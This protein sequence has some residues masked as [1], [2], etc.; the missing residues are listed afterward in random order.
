MATAVVTHAD[1]TPTPPPMPGYTWEC[2]TDDFGHTTCSAVA[3][4]TCGLSPDGKWVVPVPPGSQ[5]LI[6]APC[7][8]GPPN[9]PRAPYPTTI[10]GLS[11]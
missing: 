1:P 5:S 8:G 7:T 10:P 2:D 4:P 9:F 6:P 3:I 11:Q